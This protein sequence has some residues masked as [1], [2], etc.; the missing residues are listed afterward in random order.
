M[1]RVEAAFT[2]ASTP[3]QSWVST[4]QP[5]TAADVPNELADL[6]RRTHAV[7]AERDRY[8]QLGQ[9]ATDAF[10]EHRRDLTQLSQKERAVRAHREDA[11][12]T[13]LQEA[14]TAN[15][16]LMARIAEQR[17]Q[18]EEDWRTELASHR[19]DNARRQTEL[20]AVL[21][22]LHAERAQ[23]QRSVAGAEQTQDAYR[24]DIAT[25]LAEQQQLQA[26]LAL[27]R[28]GLK[29]AAAYEDNGSVSTSERSAAECEAWPVQPCQRARQPCCEYCH[30]PSQVWSGSSPTRR[31][32]RRRFVPA[33]P[34]DASSPVRA[35]SPPSHHVD[36]IVSNIERENYLRPRLYRQRC[37]RE[38]SPLRTADKALYYHSD[39]LHEIKR[40]ALPCYDAF[41]SSPSHRFPSAHRQHHDHLHRSASQGLSSTSTSAPTSTS[42]STC[43]TSTTPVE[44]VGGASSLASPSPAHSAVSPARVSAAAAPP[45]SSAILAGNRVA[46]ATENKYDSTRSAH[47]A[48]GA[49]REE[50]ST[51]VSLRRATTPSPL[52]QHNF[53]HHQRACNLDATLTRKASPSS[54][55]AFPQQQQQQR[56]HHRYNGS[57]INAACHALLSALADT[58]AEYHRYQQQL[59]DP[60]GDSVTASQQMRCLM[61]QMDETMRQIRALRKEQERHRDPLRVHDVLQQIVSENRYCEAVYQDLVEL[62]RS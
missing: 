41:D 27:L 13:Q 22:G 20:Q 42:T 62:I 21:A 14:L 47:Q 33:G 59:R 8:R 49:V 18:H 44:S 19:A 51:P 3:S 38:A 28:E 55:P 37:G 48:E 50:R 43:T 1:E 7:A 52:R 40:V 39:C 5:P 32:P 29:T 60:K 17:R 26:K 30:V 10:E 11:L 56:Q 6:R 16:S 15:R 46:F 24:H 25:C 36:A 35:C 57:A 2:P 45:A 12:R 4:S 61:R 53:S 58:R 31:V 23:L 34:W 54:T 9:R